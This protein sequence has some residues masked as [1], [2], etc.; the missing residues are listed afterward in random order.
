MEKLVW[1]CEEKVIEIVFIFNSNKIGIYR[2]GRSF[3]YNLF[4]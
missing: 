4:N 1:F 2:V 3:Y